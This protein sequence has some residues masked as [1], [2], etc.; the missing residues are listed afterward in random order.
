LAPGDVL[1]D[2][3]A[4][5]V[6]TETLRIKKGETITIETWNPGLPLAKRL[7]VE[8]RKAGAVPVMMFEDEATFVESVKV[9]PKDVLGTMGKQEYGLLAGSDAYVFLPGPPI[10]TYSPRLSREEV[11]DSTRYNRS[12]YEAAEKA[13]LRG[14]R[15]P[16]GF[17]GKE[18][19][20]LYGKRPEEFFRHQLK[21]ALA[22][23]STIS[24]NGRAIGE[25]MPDGAEATLSSG[26]GTLD[27]A[28]KGELEVEDGIVDEADV[29]AGSNMTYVPPGY[30]LKQVD[31]ASVKGAVELSPAVT[32][33]GL[34]EDARL[35]FE[36]GRIAKWTSRASKKMLDELLE[37]VPP[38]KRVLS[39][40]A[41]GLNTSMRYGFGQD[42]MVSGAVALSGFGF[43][44]IARRATLAAGGTTVVEKGK[45]VYPG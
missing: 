5:K 27:F 31:S 21:A 25:V 41:V 45:L 1:L 4:K 36:G 29:A 13:R 26:R 18:Y 9:T 44:G 34:L 23:F 11:A 22:D 14:A 20:R 10:G 38:E 6:L 37:S 32:R 8:A 39:S 40:V 35:E 42:R 28:M 2:A 24:S 33:L 30:V 12:W 19:A 43:T 17:V 7:V 15:L 3:V 16:F